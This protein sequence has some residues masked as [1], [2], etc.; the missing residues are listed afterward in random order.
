M[1]PRQLAMIAGL[2]IPSPSPA[3]WCACNPAAATKPPPPPRT[4]P[5]PSPRWPRLSTSSRSN[6][7][8][9]RP[10]ARI[11]FNC[12]AI[13][14]PHS[15]CLLAT[16]SRSSKKPRRARPPVA[17]NYPPERPEFGQ[18]EHELLDGSGEPIKSPDQ[19]DLKLA[20]LGVL[21]EALQAGA[22][23]F[24][25]AHS[26]GINP[27]EVPAPLLQHLAERDLLD[28]GIL[29]E[30]ISRA[31]SVGRAYT[32]VYGGAFGFSIRHNRILLV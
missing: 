29:F 12:R 22:V 27:G 8:A 25:T 11:R 3:P 10:L 13:P 9:S 30:A 19:H 18:G 5:S 7:R 14:E 21:H 26:V 4:A 23:L 20:P 24:G 16:R 1:P 15:N 31:S 6:T 28:L 32:E 17:R 2:A